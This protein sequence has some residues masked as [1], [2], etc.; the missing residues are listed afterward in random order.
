MTYASDEDLLNALDR[1]KLYPAFYY[2]RESTNWVWDKSIDVF[3]SSTGSTTLYPIQQSYKGSILVE[4]QATALK[5][6][7]KLKFG[8]H[9]KGAVAYV[10][11]PELS[12]ETI[13]VQLRLTGISISDL[14][15]PHNAL[16]AK[17]LVSVTWQSN[18]VLFDVNSDV[19][20]VQQIRIFLDES[21]T[22]HLTHTDDMAPGEVAETPIITIVPSNP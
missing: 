5:I 9:S 2:S 8:W 19:Q 3:E 21:D 12:S 14:Q 22:P 6:A 15:D 11:V 4:N 7:S 20:E 10:H 17:R 18:L 1:I 13:P 16:G